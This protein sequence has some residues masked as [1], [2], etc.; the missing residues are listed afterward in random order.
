MCLLFFLRRPC[1][2][3]PSSHP[4]SLPPASDYAIAHFGR[5]NVEAGLDFLQQTV[6]PG[7]FPGG[8]Q[9]AQVLLL[10]VSKSCV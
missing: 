6:L 8:Q 3:S 9:P 4:P 1:A 7:V 10:C 5:I 2:H